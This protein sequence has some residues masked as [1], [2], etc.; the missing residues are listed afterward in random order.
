MSPSLQMKNPPW[1]IRLWFNVAAALTSLRLLGHPATR[2]GKPMLHSYQG[3][4]PTMPLP[5]VRDTLRRHLESV[6][7]LFDDR[8]YEEMAALS[9]EFET[10]MAPRLQRCIHTVIQLLLISIEPAYD[11]N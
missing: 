1:H 10:S 6:R 9:R 3:A 4:M 7:P 11:A 5:S 8:E 2:R